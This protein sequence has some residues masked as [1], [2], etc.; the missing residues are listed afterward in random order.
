[1]KPL[2]SVETSGL[3]HRHGM[4]SQKDGILNVASVRTSDFTITE[5]LWKSSGRRRSF[6]IKDLGC[7]NIPLG[8]GFVLGLQW[9][10][11]TLEWSLWV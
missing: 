10:G 7:D 9:C 3:T 2:E 5:S 8:Q 6:Q 4:I 11:A 1:M